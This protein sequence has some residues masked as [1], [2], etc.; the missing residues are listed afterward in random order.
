MELVIV[1]VS[2]AHTGA[3][4]A[5]TGTRTG[6]RT[7][8]RIGSVVVTVAVTGT[9]RGAGAGAGTAT[10]RGGLRAGASSLLIRDIVCTRF[11]SLEE[12]YIRRVELR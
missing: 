5:R 9:G 12:T 10:G 7:G 11:Q 2:F 6:R 8:T 3:G 4:I 1:I